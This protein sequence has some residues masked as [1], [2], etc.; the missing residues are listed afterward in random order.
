MAHLLHGV[1]VLVILTQKSFYFLL[2]ARS[3]VLK[4]AFQI[5]SMLRS[6]L[7]SKK[8]FFWLVGWSVCLPLWLPL[9][10]IQSTVG[11]G[12]QRLG[13]CK[14]DLT[15]F[16]S[17]I[18]EPGLLR[19]TRTARHFLG[20][21]DLQSNAYPVPQLIPRMPNVQALES[22]AVRALSLGVAGHMQ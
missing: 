12:W 18:L 16:Q 5:L 10:A 14:T 4:G 11:S 6:H 1:F 19:L 3:D 8:W 2:V 9:L 21:G 15:N 22:S 7:L 20:E 17:S 13:G